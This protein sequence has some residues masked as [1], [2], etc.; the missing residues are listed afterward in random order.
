MEILYGIAMLIV[1][2]LGLIIGLLVPYYIKKYVNQIQDEYKELKS[3]N[4]LRESNKPTSL[5]DEIIDEWVNGGD[6]NAK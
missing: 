4:N 2:L 3:D 5:T 6:Q 1:F